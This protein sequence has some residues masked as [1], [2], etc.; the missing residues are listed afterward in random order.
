M[1]IYRSLCQ[2]ICWGNHNET[3]GKSKILMNSGCVMNDK[4][5]DNIIVS[6]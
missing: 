4:N 5:G 2:L 3:I 6:S 1:F